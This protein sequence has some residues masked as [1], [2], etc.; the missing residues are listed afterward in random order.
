MQTIKTTI[1]DTIYLFNNNI[2]SSPILRPLYHIL[3]L[4][5]K[6]TLPFTNL[7]ILTRYHKHPP[8]HIIFHTPVFS[9][10]NP[11]S[12]SIH[13][14]VPF[15]YIP[16]NPYLLNP[17]FNLSS[18]ETQ[19]PMITIRP[20]L[21]YEIIIPSSPVFITYPTYPPYTILVLDPNKITRV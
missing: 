7:P 2:N 15:Q 6:L 5:H 10:L 21:P 4:I 20:V 13:E 19:Q 1:H 11:P 17:T 12:Q 3:H 9:R 18:T 8:L 14:S 16:V